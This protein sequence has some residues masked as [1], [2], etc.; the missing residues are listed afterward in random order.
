MS[1]QKRRLFISLKDSDWFFLDWKFGNKSCSSLSLWEG[2][3]IGWNGKGMEIWGGPTKHIG[4]V[5]Q[6]G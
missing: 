6:M 2:N 3:G 4:G 1:G 5:G